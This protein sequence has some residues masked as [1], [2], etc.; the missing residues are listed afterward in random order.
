MKRLNIFALFSFLMGMC[1]MRAVDDDGAGGGEGSDIFDEDLDDTA[2]SGV[3]G[4]KK[5][6]DGT[7]AETKPPA[8]EAAP[9]PDKMLLEEIRQER[10][11]NDITKELKAEHGDFE[12]DKVIAKLKEMEKEKPGSGN[13][14]FNKAGIELVHLKYFAN[15]ESDGE[16]DGKGGRGSKAPSK[17]ELI[18]K[19][20][21]G[22]ASDDERQAFY[23]QFA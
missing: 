19:I 13:K 23:A 14:L 6:G 4:E 10:A 9:D 11:L 17:D 12:M 2:S 8:K 1:F 3:A 20:N 21:K 22:E 15:A 5:E 16:F 18:S 7:K